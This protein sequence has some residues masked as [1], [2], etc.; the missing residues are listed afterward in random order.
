MDQEKMTD[1]AVGRVLAAQ[2]GD[3]VPERVAGSLANGGFDPHGSTD[4]AGAA[5]FL[6]LGVSTLERM[7]C[8]GGGPVF[9]K[10]TDGPNGRVTYDYSDLVAYKASRK[11]R[12]TSGTSPLKG[13]RRNGGAS[14]STPAAA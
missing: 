8:R 3:I 10:L 6:G 4:T 11:Q 1:T 9:N 7:R 12:S 2:G 5:D 13:Q 14:A